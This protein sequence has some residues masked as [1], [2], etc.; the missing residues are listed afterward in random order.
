VQ[1]LRSGGSAGTQKPKIDPTPFFLIACLVLGACGKKGPPLPPLQR[2]PGAPADLTITRIE[3]VVYARLVVPTANVDGVA[4]ADVARVELYAITSDRSPL[5]TDLDELRELATLI[6][7]E[8]VRRPLPPLPPLEE[9][10][11]PIPLPPAGPGVDQGATLVWREMLTPTMQ[12]AVALP[13]LDERRPEP[14][15]AVEIPRPLVAP[16][17]VGGPQ[18]YYFA[19]AVSQRGRYG[20]TTAFAPVP[21]GPTSSAPAAPE[22]SV[23]EKSMT[24]K[25]KPAPDAR[26]AIEPT[27]PD[28]LP[29]RPTAAGPPPTTYDVYEVSQNESPDAPIAVPTPLTA[30]PIGALELVQ[31]SV[32]AGTA[33]CFVVRPVDIVSGIHVRGPASPP[34]CASFADTYAPSAPA[35][36]A[37][38]AVPGTISLI[39][40]PVDAADLAGYLVLRGEAGSAT[41]APLTKE[42]IRETTYRD[43]SVRA[44]TGYIYAIVAVDKAGNR[45]AESNRIEE[46]ARQ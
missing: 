37:A 30:A 17:E 41:L 13:E 29:S 23:D 34:V 9:G 1:F 21:L 33:R 45:S 25:W 10:A 32:S 14:E 6:A 22:I 44:G 35:R 26:G 3:D 38:V 42:P 16:F 24:L 46:T 4:P 39:W 40:D 19:V 15:E 12:T 18:R 43:G 28:L 36:L 2:I 27:P 11:P 31:P 8:T 20:P 7:S 5:G